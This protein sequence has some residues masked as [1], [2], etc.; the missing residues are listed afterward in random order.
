MTGFL[1]SLGL[2]RVITLKRTNP[3]DPFTPFSDNPVPLGRIGITGQILILLEFGPEG[4]GNMIDADP[5]SAAFDERFDGKKLGPVD[6]IFDNGAAGQIF[7]IENFLRNLMALINF[8][9]Y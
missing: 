7:K 8:G 9:A 3:D 1:W 4:L 5:L 6:N 2:H